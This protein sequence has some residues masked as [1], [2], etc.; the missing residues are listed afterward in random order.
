[1]WFTDQFSY[2]S[3]IFGQSMTYITVKAIKVLIFQ[4]FIY[5]GWNDGHFSPEILWW[6][7]QWVG[8]SVKFPREQ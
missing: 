4:N 2:Y 5:L 8:G 7:F 3:E 1:M 6:C